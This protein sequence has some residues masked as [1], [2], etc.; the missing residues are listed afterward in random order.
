MP[1]GD[2]V[3]SGLSE[4]RGEL[5]TVKPTQSLPPCLG[6]APPVAVRYLRLQRFDSSSG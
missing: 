4:R 1:A 3:E 5:A 2:S 6:I